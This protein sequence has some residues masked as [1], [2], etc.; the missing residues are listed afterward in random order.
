MTNR[1]IYRR[2]F[3]VVSTL[4]LALFCQGTFDRA[5]AD[6]V[7]TPKGD[8]PMIHWAILEST[9]GEMTQMQAL[10]RELVAPR[11]AH[12]PGTYALYGGVDA[13]N[14]NRLYLLEI[15]RD[16]DAY[17]IHVGSD[18]FKE[19]KARRANIL[20]ELVILPVQPIALEQKVGEG[21]EIWARNVV[22]SKDAAKEYGE[23][24]RREAIEAVRR[25][26]G[27]MGFFVTQDDE[28]GV[29]WILEAFR[30]SAAR[31]AYR[32]SSEYRAFRRDVDPLELRND[33]W[34]LN[35]GVM[36]LS[37]KYREK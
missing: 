1:I 35:A 34:K 22:V 16:E 20:K 30:N 18:E 23:R 24:I 29:F 25:D 15:Y 13:S 4:L 17:E 26:D 27:V 28:T 21:T 11:V 8:A 31:T 5:K 12:E 3:F 2:R 6:S 32:E 10:A 14:P 33:E 9:P 37:D 7:R 19:Y 36:T